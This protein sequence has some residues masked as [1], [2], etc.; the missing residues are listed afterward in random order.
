MS[1]QNLK[2]ILAFVLHQYKK[3]YTY[4]SMIETVKREMKPT[5]SLKWQ[6]LE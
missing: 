1:S 2:F 6:Y 4:S 3:P 5:F